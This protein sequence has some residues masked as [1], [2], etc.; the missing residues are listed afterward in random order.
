MTIATNGTFT[1]LVLPDLDSVRIFQRPGRFIAKIDESRN[2][3]KGSVSMSAVRFQ[4]RLGDQ[5]ATLMV[6]DGVLPLLGFSAEDFN[7]GKIA[8]RERFH[9]DDADI[10]ELVFGLSMV[11]GEHTF[12]A[13]PKCGRPRSLRSRAVQQ[14]SP[15]IRTVAG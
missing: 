4:L 2:M 12:N 13:S 1:I 15:G 9:A 7:S 14:D 3:P 10:A 11:P 5:L 8:L 6:S